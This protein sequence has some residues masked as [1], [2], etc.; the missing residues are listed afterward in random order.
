MEIVR[1]VP[2][3]HRL[4][5]AARES[6]AVV[7]V[8]TM[9]A[10]HAGHLA[11]IRRARNLGGT[12]V[13]SIFVNP[14]QFGPKEDL[15][16][17]PRPFR[18]DAKGCADA[19]AD[20]LY[21]PS[22]GQIYPP[23]FSTFVEETSVSRGLCGRSRPGHFRGVCT[24]VHKLFQ[25]VRPTHAIF[26]RKDFQQ[27]AVIQRMVRDLHL[28]VRLI[29]APTVREPDGLAMSS[30]NVFLTKEQ[31]AAAPL[32][33]QGLREALSQFMTGERG[34]NPLREAVRIAVAGIPDCR[35]DYIELCDADSLEPVEVVTGRTVLAVAA[36]VGSLPPSPL[37][38][39]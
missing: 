10:L 20:I 30:R 12:V 24:V 25:L 1:S 6:G 33:Y 23:G 2:K 36:Y 5:D 31:R 15:S 8:P 29:M 39:K 21:H 37:K 34:S 16:R 26:G 9:G 11:L 4:I 3:L 22:V 14:T 28:P 35:I 13:V 18:R 19:G 27:C 38:R 32:I 17:Y 7:L